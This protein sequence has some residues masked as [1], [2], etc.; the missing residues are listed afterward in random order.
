MLVRNSLESREVPRTLR[1]LCDGLLA[2]VLQDA[3]SFHKQQ[4]LL[5]RA[6]NAAHSGHRHPC[7]PRGDALPTHADVGSPP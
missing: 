1:F 7:W 5:C 3:S 4:K 6:Q 2:S